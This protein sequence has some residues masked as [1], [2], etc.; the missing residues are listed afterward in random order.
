MANH[1]R[2]DRV[3]LEAALIDVLLRERRRRRMAQQRLEE[4]LRFEQLVSELSGTFI[5]LASEKVETRII[6]ALGQVASLLSFDIATLSVFTGRGTEGRARLH[7]E[8]EGLYRKYPSNLTDKDFPWSA[9]ELFAGR[10]VCLPTLGGCRR[11]PTSIA[12]RIEQYHVQSSYSVP[13]VAGGKLI[14]VLGFNSG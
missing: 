13:I 8:G 6:E 12:P 4:R 5:N 10:D 1:Y 7:L 3:L 11:K 14:G 2:L 9:R